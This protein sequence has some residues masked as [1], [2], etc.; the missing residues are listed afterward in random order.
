MAVPLPL[1]PSRQRV[2]SA[3][4]R[5]KDSGMPQIM[6][7]VNV[8]PDSFHKGSRKTT[9]ESAIEAGIKAWREGATWVDIGGEST[10]PGADEVSIEEELS[11]VIPVITALRTAS[12][13]GLISIDTRNYLVA[14]AALRAG[15]DLINDVSGLRDAKMVELII[16]SKCGVCIM[17][18]LGEPGNMQKNPQYDDVLSEV[19][20]NLFSRAAIL[21]DR[22]HDPKLICLDPGIGFGKNLHHNLEL[23]RTPSSLRGKERYE[24]AFSGSDG[25]GFSILWGVSRKSMFKQ[26][27]GRESSDERLSGTLGVAAVAQR[28][29]IDVLRVHDVKEHHDLLTTICALQ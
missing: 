4:L 23:L 1:P 22:G 19:S 6:G 2:V 16:K 28:T 10:R 8:T 24:E 11:R 17:H 15:A 3:G 21:I 7:I 29:G 18:M 12:P 26:L 5:V 27:L 13:E 14:E 25:S 20:E 9:L